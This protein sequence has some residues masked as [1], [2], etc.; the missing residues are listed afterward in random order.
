MKVRW[1][2]VAAIVVLLTW[3]TYPFVLAGSKPRPLDAISTAMWTRPGGRRWFLRNL[4][5]QADAIEQGRLLNWC[6]GVNGAAGVGAASAKPTARDIDGAGSDDAT[7]DIRLA[8]ALA[9]DRSPEIGAYD[10]RHLRWALPRCP[11]WDGA[12]TSPTGAPKQWFVRRY[13]HLIDG[14]PTERKIDCL[15][16][17]TREDVEPI[18]IG[19]GRL[20]GLESVSRD[21]ESVTNWAAFALQGALRDADEPA[22]RLKE[23]MTSRRE[24][25]VLPILLREVVFHGGI[26]L[27]PATSPRDYTD[28]VRRLTQLQPTEADW[29]ALGRSQFDADAL[30]RFHATYPIADN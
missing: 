14:F 2:L 6:L 29:D 11:Y 3:V 27:E 26:R 9:L 16:A 20:G 1:F 22:A 8:I 19:A 21:L 10:Q 5:R 7:R 30:R 25:I 4:A 17:I 24:S 15:L 18:A 13:A 23:W 28:L 12:T